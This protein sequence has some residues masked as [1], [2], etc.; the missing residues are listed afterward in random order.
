MLDSNSEGTLIDQ[1]LSCD[2]LGELCFQAYYFL[3]VSSKL[4]FLSELCLVDHP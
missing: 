3:L 2:S 1:S 4:L